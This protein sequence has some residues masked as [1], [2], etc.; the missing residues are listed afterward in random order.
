MLAGP[1]LPRAVREECGQVRNKGQRMGGG[2]PG[3]KASGWV[4]SQCTPHRHYFAGEG[5]LHVSSLYLTYAVMGIC[6]IPPYRCLSGRQPPKLL[7]LSAD[8]CRSLHRQ[9]RSPQP[10]TEPPPPVDGDGG[11]GG[12]AAQSTEGSVASVAGLPDEQLSSARSRRR[13]LAGMK[14]A[15]QGTLHRK[16][17]CV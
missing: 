1:G 4:E 16:G 15:E 14:A 11:G 3:W 9:H 17:A 12:R 7:H 8:V 5:C 6:P 13:L 10:P 2:G